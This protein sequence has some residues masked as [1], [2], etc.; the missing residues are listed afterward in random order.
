M[1]I[2]TR[3]GILGGLQEEGCTIS[4]FSA[5]NYPNVKNKGAMLKINKNLSV[6]PCLI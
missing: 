2:N 5:T 6:V 1:I 3:D 4:I